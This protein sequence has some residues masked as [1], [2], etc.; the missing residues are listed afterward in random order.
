[1]SDEDLQYLADLPFEH[2]LTADGLNLQF[3]HATPQDVIAAIRPT[4]PWPQIETR[5]AGTAADWVIMGHI[6]EP[7][8]FKF[9]GKTLINTG[10]I[11]FSLDGDWRASYAVLDTATRSIRLNRVT[12]DLHAAVEAA[13]RASF[14]FDPEWYGAA[15]RMG[16]WENIPYAKRRTEIDHFQGS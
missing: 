8:C 4:D 11:G 14:C 16:F 5:L 7:F 3:V 9:A 2:R 12:Y 6:H 15:L 1:M 13:R 10:A